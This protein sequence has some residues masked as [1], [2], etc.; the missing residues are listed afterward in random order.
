MTPEE[1]L[2][3]EKGKMVG[4]LQERARL[5]AIIMKVRW[6]DDDSLMHLMQECKKELP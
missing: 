1:K 5:C 3:F 4:A 2:S 6:T